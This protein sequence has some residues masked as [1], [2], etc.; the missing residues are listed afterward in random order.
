[1]SLRVRPQTVKFASKASQMGRFTLKLMVCGEFPCDLHAR[2]M[3]LTVRLAGFRAAGVG[4]I[5]NPIGSVS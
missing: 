2:L 4:L 5:V 3:A 1:M